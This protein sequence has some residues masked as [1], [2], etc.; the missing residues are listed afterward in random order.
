ME[1]DLKVIVQKAEASQD[2][3][4]RQVPT[5]SD[6]TVFQS[7]LPQIA[8]TSIANILIM[9]PYAGC[10]DNASNK[11]SV[12]AFHPDSRRLVDP[13]IFVTFMSVCAT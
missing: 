7:G 1:F 3:L 13:V 4:R 2:S 9:I 6:F 10:Y 8:K 5:S 12:A 11:I